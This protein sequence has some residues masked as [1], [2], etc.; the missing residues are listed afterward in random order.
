MEHKSFLL[1]SRPVKL[2]TS[3][4][5]LLLS[6]SLHGL[7]LV[8]VL[9]LVLNLNKSTAKLEQ[10]LDI[11]IVDQIKP[12]LEQTE[13]ITPASIIK[14][15]LPDEI[16]PEDKLPTDQPKDN[17]IEPELP[18]FNPSPEAKLTPDE[19]NNPRVET[20]PPLNNSK[21]AELEPQPP[22]S[23]EPRFDV[24]NQIFKKEPPAE[25]PPPDHSR[26]PEIANMPILQTSL[27]TDNKQLNYAL[28]NYQWSYQT[29][30]EQWA[31]KIQQN[32]QAPGDY[33]AGLVPEGGNLWISAK[34][35]KQ[36]RLLAFRLTQSNV[37]G[38]MEKKALQG[39]MASFEIPQLPDDFPD[40]TTFYW[41]LIYPSYAELR[42]YE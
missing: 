4:S 28:S 31:L 40:G 8:L 7:L 32:W 19:K 30:I 41:N 3:S 15:P 12:R 1:L 17:E 21:L 38:E 33:I 26:P 34:I 11:E 42:G 14:Q 5:Q 35:S 16:G 10:I 29:Y 27:N 25:K 18:D 9:L 6:F 2:L 23:D 39:F 20:A 36:G 24:N 13:K 22:L 37:S